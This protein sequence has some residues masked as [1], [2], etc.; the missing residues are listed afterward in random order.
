MVKASH[1][2]FIVKG[3]GIWWKIYADGSGPQPGHGLGGLDHFDLYAMYRLL[4]PERTSL[5]SEIADVEELV[6]QDYR[7]FDCDQDLGLGMTLWTCSFFPEETWARTVAARCLTRLE[8]LWVDK[9]A[10]GGYFARAPWA[11][12]L[13]VAFANCGVGIGLQAALTTPLVPAADRAAWRARVQRLHAFLD[14]HAED[15][16]E[17]AR[18]AITWVM[19]CNTHYPGWL[20]PD[21]LPSS[22]AAKAGMAPPAS[23]KYA[24]DTGAG[25]GG[26][27]AGAAETGVGVRPK[28]GAGGAGKAGQPGQSALSTL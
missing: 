26:M 2:C 22:G 23:V 17:Y 10:Q 14:K 19:M 20:C 18:E 16:P 3:R 6:M 9:G 28:A 25:S 11:R 24:P 12:N 27:N 8:E 21:A 5:A 15:D 13:L 4:D 1:P 7:R